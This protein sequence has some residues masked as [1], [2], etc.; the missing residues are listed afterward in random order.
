MAKSCKSTADLHLQS[1]TFRVLIPSEKRRLFFF[2][3][4]KGMR[5]EYCFPSPFSDEDDDDISIELLETTD[6]GPDLRGGLGQGVQAGLDHSISR[7]SVIARE[8]PIC[9]SF[10]FHKNLKAIKERENTFG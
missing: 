9:D 6:L 8:P 4:E 5:S 2:W 1:H 10:L 3:L 7:L